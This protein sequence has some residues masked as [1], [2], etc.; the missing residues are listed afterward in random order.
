MLQL[1]IVLLLLALVAGALGFGGMMT[2]FASAA[3]ILFYVF[4]VLFLISAVA[5]ALRRRPP[6]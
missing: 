2:S 6:V 1:A 3:Q 5:S 4:I